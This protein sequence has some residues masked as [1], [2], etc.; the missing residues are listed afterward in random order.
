MN[1]L[2]QVRIAVQTAIES[3]DGIL[4]DEGKL[5]ALLTQNRIQTHLH[6]I[7]QVKELINVAVNHK[8]YANDTNAQTQFTQMKNEI[9]AAEKRL[10]A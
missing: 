3:I 6:N 10:T 9:A 4:E 8:A 2:E 7:E 5:G 1:M